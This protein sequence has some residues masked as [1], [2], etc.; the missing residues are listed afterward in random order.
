MERA[1]SWGRESV[2]KQLNHGIKLTNKLKKQ[3]HHH[4]NSSEC[5]FLIHSIVSCYDNALAML[6]YMDSLQTGD[7]TTSFDFSPTSG[8]S[9][10]DFK[11][12]IP[13]KR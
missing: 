1:E 3:L 5:G 4:S 11:N 12:H 8:V 6:N 9:D 10:Q 2:I 7:S 13:K